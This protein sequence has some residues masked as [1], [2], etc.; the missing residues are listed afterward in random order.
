MLPV[1][2]MFAVGCQQD[3]LSRPAPAW[4]KPQHSRVGSLRPQGEPS[5]LPVTH[6][7]SAQL[8]EE[9]G[10]LTG[11]LMQYRQA[12]AL[13]HDFIAAYERLGLL[14]DR[15]GHYYEAE[16]VWVK[17]IE[18]AP[19]NPSLHNNLGFHHLL[20]RHYRQAAASFD[21]ALLAD[22]T[23]DRARV[24]LGITLA[25]LGQTDEALE[26]FRQALTEDQAQY[27]LGLVLR[28][29]LKHEEARRAFEA[30]LRANPGLTAARVHLAGL[31]ST[32]AEPG[33]PLIETTTAGAPAAEL[34]AAE[35]RAVPSLQAAS[36]PEPA[37]SAPLVTADAGTEPAPPPA[38]Q[39][40]EL[41]P[42][43]EPETAFTAALALPTTPPAGASPQAQ[44]LEPSELRSLEAEMPAPEMP[45]APEPLLLPLEPVDDFE[46]EPSPSPV[47][48]WDASPEWALAT[49]AIT[50]RLHERWA[51]FM[52]TLRDGAQMMWD[53]PRV[54]HAEGPVERPLTLVQTADTGSSPGEIPEDHPCWGEDQTFFDVWGDV[55]TAEWPNEDFPYDLENDFPMQERTA[56]L[57]ATS[58]PRPR[59]DAEDDQDAAWR[60]TPTERYREL[61]ADEETSLAELV[62]AKMDGP[63]Q[64]LA[65]TISET[66]T[67]VDFDDVDDAALSPAHP[68][69]A[70]PADD[71]GAGDQPHPAE[72]QGLLIP[73]PTSGSTASSLAAAAMF[74]PG[75]DPLLPWDLSEELPDSQVTHDAS[76][77]RSP[78]GY[79]PM[80]LRHDHGLSQMADW[81]D[82]PGSIR[83]IPRPIR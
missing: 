74:E 50:A 9:S 60:S 29:N 42:V 81:A 82:Q 38:E 6:F 19:N 41:T 73:R 54:S 72:L 63:M 12:I 45:T 58:S 27:N 30:A 55:S 70:A 7:A 24:N 33:Q 48:L 64:P 47:A 76:P 79:G 35:E 53:R 4:E 67:W 80:T 32:T 83:P 43:Q 2:M 56:E 26:S 25:Q 71:L 28:Q 78:A 77:H 66:R 13:N 34:A 18:R 36:E 3:T 59:P 61:L 22:P 40:L 37:K 14:L 17:A 52:V 57:A 62:A 5:L 11:A 69:F 75:A 1:F 10:D 16:Q 51:M 44:D 46:A 68:V 8:L 65:P 20:Q 23:Y 31:P 49:N 39:V 21:N 15:V